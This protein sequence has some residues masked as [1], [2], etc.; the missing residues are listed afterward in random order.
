MGGFMKRPRR[1]DG[2]LYCTPAG[3]IRL[4]YW[5]TVIEDGVTQ[6]KRK[7]TLL[8]QQDDKHTAEKRG[9]KWVFSNAVLV[10][11]DRLMLEVND[12]SDAFHQP[13]AKPNNRTIRGFYE[14]VYLPWAFQ[15]LRKSTIRGYS[16]IWKTHLKAHFGTLTFLD[17]NTLMASKYLTS[18]A[19]KGL[20][21]R[22]IAHIR[23][24]ASGIFGH[25]LAHHGLIPNNPWENARSAR[26]YTK[27]PPTEFYTVEQAVAIIE[28]FKGDHPDWSALI[29]LCFYAGLRPSEAVAIQWTDFRNRDGQ[30]F[31]HIARGY[32]E[33]AVEDTKT[34]D[35]KAAIPVAQQLQDILNLWNLKS[36]RKKTGWLFSDE[37]GKKPIDL[38]NL[39]KRKLVPAVQE[40][41]F[42]WYGL[43]AFRRGLATH[44]NSLGDIVAA[45][46]MLRHAHP[47]TT[48]KHYAKLTAG[49]KIRALKYLEA[50]LPEQTAEKQ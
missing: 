20:T 37:S 38:H 21:A 7:D 35:S 16:Q 22:T 28:A 4:K 31:L 50:G 47:D 5:T 11:K 30:W 42:P 33:G 10:M 46:S 14:N 48:E 24:L 39:Y 40:E 45:Q 34:Q 23:A 17:Y 18:L 13:V 19:E 15:E 32:V 29:G 3:A 2:Q 41:G 44:L 25:A 26:K 1:Q 6:R 49:D 9:D 43:Y 27:A 12:K 36:G 8:C